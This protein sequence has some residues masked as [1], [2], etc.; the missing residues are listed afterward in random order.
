M[1]SRTRKPHRQ[2]PRPNRHGTDA[3]VHFRPLDWFRSRSPVIKFVSLFVCL[4]AGYYILT[5][6][7]F[8]KSH[9]FPFVIQVNAW[10]SSLV[11]NV[12][13]QGTHVEGSIIA[14]EVFAVDIKR[15]CDALE[16][17]AFF[18]IGVLTYPSSLR[19]KIPGILAGAG[20]LFALNIVRIVS[21]FL[22]GKHSQAA[23]EFL[24]VDVWQV[25]FILGA[26]VLWVLWIIW[27]AG[28]APVP[29]PAPAS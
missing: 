14:S 8:F 11:L 2:P 21:L 20:V 23:F 18:S 27:A 4:L 10:L 5:Q 17:I 19:T 29:A 6:L 22:V 26:I 7:P 16:P 1:A 3:K 15:G 25:L 28:K 12:L 9:I 13:G 24:H